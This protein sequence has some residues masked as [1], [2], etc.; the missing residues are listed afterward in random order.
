MAAIGV[1]AH[2]DVDHQRIRGQRKLLQLLQELP[3]HLVVLCNHAV[4]AST[5]SVFSASR[6]NAGEG[7][8]ELTV[9]GCL[10]PDLSLV[11]RWGVWVVVPGVAQ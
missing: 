4:C 6:S 3:N 11:A 9:V 5:G 8:A 1:A 10:L 7:A 2:G